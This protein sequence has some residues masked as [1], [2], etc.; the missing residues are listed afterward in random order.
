MRETTGEQVGTN[1]SDTALRG[2]V[3]YNMKRAFNA[4]QADLTRTLAPHGLRMIT[5][6]VLALVVE[7]PR[8][9]PS[10]LAKALTVERANLVVY[11]DQLEQ[12]GWVTRTP[13][14][15]DRRA[16]ALQATLE[17]QQVYARAMAAVRDHDQRMLGALDP[18][19]VAVVNKA[20]ATIEAQGRSL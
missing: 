5:Y 6:S 7:N 11:V 10:A 14:S 16:Y 13:S 17:G 4:V 12:A 9:R 15:T 8:L 3:G 1:V 20:L 19:D 2:F 18:S